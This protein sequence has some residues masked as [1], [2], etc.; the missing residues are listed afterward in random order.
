MQ[1]PHLIYHDQR[2][3]KRFGINRGNIG[4]QALA[5]LLVVLVALLFEGGRPSRADMSVLESQL[6]AYQADR[7]KSSIDL[8]QFRTTNSISVAMPDGKT[9][10]ITLINLNP[11]VNRWYLLQVSREG[12]DATQ[13]YHLFNPFP[14]RQQVF[15]NENSPDGLILAEDSKT[16]LCSLWQPFSGGELDAARRTQQAYAPLCEERLYLRNPV[17]GHR[18]AIE[19]VTDFLRDNFRAEMPS[20]GS[21]GIHFSR[22]HIERKPAR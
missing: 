6:K 3:T 20:S 16:V 1:S 14:Q 5:F 9:A 2:T 18:T 12:H 19:A 10:K 17:K 7:P 22:M 21:C 13:N 15:L 8:Q 4:R 11:Y